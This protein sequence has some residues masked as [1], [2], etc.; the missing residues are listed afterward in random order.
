M[1]LWTLSVEDLQSKDKMGNSEEQQGREERRGSMGVQQLFA[2]CT[3]LGIGHHLLNNLEVLICALPQDHRE[4]L[5]PDFKEGFN[6]NG[7]ETCNTSQSKHSFI[8]KVQGKL[9]ALATNG[10]F[11]AHPF[12][13]PIASAF[14]VRPELRYNKQD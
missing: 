1:L 9:E 3:G 4:S 14:G 5:I 7:E 6:N 10:I 11:I 2:V 8:L 13:C 12:T